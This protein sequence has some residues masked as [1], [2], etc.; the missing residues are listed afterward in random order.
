MPLLRP[1]RTLVIAPSQRLDLIAAHHADALP[2]PVKLPAPRHRRHEP[3]GAAP[4]QLPP[5][6]TKPPT[7]AL[8][9]LGYKDTME[10]AEE[11]GTSSNCEPALGAAIG[12]QL[13]PPLTETTAPGP[14]FYRQLARAGRGRTSP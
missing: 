4:D 6:R 10:R 7:R 2:R 12:E 14:R 5:V 3:A 8:I 13:G 11:C 9:D 1:I